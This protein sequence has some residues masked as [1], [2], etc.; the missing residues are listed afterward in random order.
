MDLQDVC[1]VFHEPDC[2]GL[3]TSDGEGGLTCAECGQRVGTVQ[4]AVLKEIIALISL[5]KSSK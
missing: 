3:I 2:P 4:P 1:M 5:V